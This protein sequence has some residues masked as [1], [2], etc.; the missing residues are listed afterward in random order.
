[1]KAYRPCPAPA[2]RAGDDPNRASAREPTGPG[3]RLWVAALA[4][5]LVAAGLSPGDAIAQ[6][7]GNKPKQPPAAE[8]SPPAD[9]PTT[10]KVVTLPVAGI[11]WGQ[12]PK[13]VGIVVDK[14]LED[15]YRP[16]YKKASPGI[17]MKNLD[18]ALAEEKG[19]F[20]R[21]RIDFGK[22]PTGLDST[23]LRGEYTYM[24][25]ES[26]MT[27]A[28]AGA[29]T[30]HFFFIQDKLWKII[31][32]HK[33]DDK[34]AFGVDFQA[35]VTKLATTFGVAGRVLP[36]DYEKGRSATEVDWKD[37]ATHVRAIQRGE[38]ALA[39]AYEDN[40]TLSILPS[41]RTNKP[42]SYDEIDPAVAAAVRSGPKEQ[43]GPPA[44][45]DPKKDK[46][47]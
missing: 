21:S 19:A 15:E 43:P 44:G 3:R 20:R 17:Q 33:L 23:P 1:M 14:L 47:K 11:A 35:A 25:K 8:P 30:R 46:Q 13:Q 40:A 5:A 32:E 9:P 4:A 29:P 36:A 39:I 7:K 42:P 12:S 24:N 18:A 45:N 27:L 26:V 6:G 22:I 28:R 31:E 10:K 37:S 34:S 41:L 2:A 38:K 16:L